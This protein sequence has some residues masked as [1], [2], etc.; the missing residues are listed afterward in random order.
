[1]SLGTLS[2][3]HRLTGLPDKKSRK[4]ARFL[5]QRSGRKPARFL[6]QRGRRKPAGSTP[7]ENGLCKGNARPRKTER[8]PPWIF[9]ERSSPW[10]TRK[11][12]RNQENKGNQQ[13]IKEKQRKS[14]QFEGKRERGERGGPWG[15]RAL[16]AR[17]GPSP[18]SPLFF[19][20]RLY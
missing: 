8:C 18:L 9:P 13:K 6:C 14:I 10:K 12:C 15:P 11:T 1:M 7:A 19:P 20:F 17:G 5:C 3:R 4:P 2:C 16:R